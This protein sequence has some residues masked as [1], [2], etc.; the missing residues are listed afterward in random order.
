[1]K[2]MRSK[3]E[4]RAQEEE[5]IALK[6]TMEFEKGDTLALI[7]AA[8]TTLFPMLLGILAIFVGIIWLLFL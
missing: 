6:R 5:L 1:M 3:E 7:I 4:I 8:F 2:W